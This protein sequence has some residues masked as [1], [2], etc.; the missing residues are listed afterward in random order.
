MIEEIDD[1]EDLLEGEESQEE[2]SQET[3]EHHRFEV[4]GGQNPL[5]VDKFIMAR[6]PNA[7]RTKIQDSAEL[8][9]I[10]VN[11]KAVRSSYKVK[12]DDV[13]TI[14][15]SYPQREIKII[16]E[17]LPLDVVYEDDVLMVVNKPVGMVVHP[18]YGHYSGTLINALAWHLKDN[19]LFKTD[20]PRPGLVHRIDKDTSG[21]LVIAKTEEAKKH[22]SL[23]FF[24]KTSERKYI[25]VCWGNLD[26]ES[27]TITGHIGRNLSNRKVMNCFPDGSYGKHAVTHYTVLE[28]LGYVNVVECRLETG[29]THQIRAHFKHIQHPLFNDKDYGGHLILRGTTFNKY[30]QFVNNCFN[31]CPRQALHAKTLGFVHPTTGEQ[32]SFN[33]EIP[34]D[35]QQLIEKWRGYV[36]YRDEMNW[37][38]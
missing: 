24:N 31:L 15:M 12:P 37:N 17:D 36:Q 13:V 33:S 34:S 20:D 7:S 11:G 25:A 4:D 21:L 29:R 8:N 18:S 27:G 26:S 22:L 9:Q 6:L 35:M 32:M 14:V 3:F 2:Q 38:E 5:R 23:Q 30:K 1:I 10:L 16:P 19:P 28:H